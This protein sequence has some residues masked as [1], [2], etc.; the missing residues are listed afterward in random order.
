M[1][2]WSHSVDCS[3]FLGL[4]NKVPKTEGLEM[5]DVYG[6]T[7]TESRSLSKLSARARFLLWF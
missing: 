4:Y 2:K 1:E 6:L 7:V 3:G 5:T